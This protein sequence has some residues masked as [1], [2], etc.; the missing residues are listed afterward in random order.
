L[1]IFRVDPNEVVLVS[2]IIGFISGLVHY[3]MHVPNGFP[4]NVS[5]Q[6]PV[7][8]VGRLVVVVAVGSVLLALSIAIYCIS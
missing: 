8:P 6:A 1:H 3:S 7:V 2:M 5:A 4:I